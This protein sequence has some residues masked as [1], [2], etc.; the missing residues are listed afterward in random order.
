MSDETVERV[1]DNSKLSI[2]ADGLEKL[3][4]YEGV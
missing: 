2:S 3:K 1:I 4:F